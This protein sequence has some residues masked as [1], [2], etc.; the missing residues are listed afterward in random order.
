MSTRFAIQVTPRLLG[1]VPSAGLLVHAVALSF[2]V[3]SE[4]QRRFPSLCIN[5]FTTLRTTSLT[6]YGD[7]QKSCFQRLLFSSPLCHTFY[8]FLDCHKNLRQLGFLIWS[9]TTLISIF[10]SSDQNLM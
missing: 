10:V 6:C 4:R 1:S 2:Y 3:N 5:H 8:F 9:F 7:F